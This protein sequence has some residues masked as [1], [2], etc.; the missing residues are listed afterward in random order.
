M[1][2]LLFAFLVVVLCSAWLLLWL[3]DAPP[4]PYS[5]V[6]PF[7]GLAPVVGSFFD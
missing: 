5:S 4:Q 3:L 2:L 7:C 6:P 1:S